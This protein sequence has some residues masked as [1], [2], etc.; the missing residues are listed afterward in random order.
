MPTSTLISY[1]LVLLLQ[2]F[3]PTGRRGRRPLRVRSAKGRRRRP[4]GRRRRH[5]GRTRRRR[6]FRCGDERVERER[7]HHS[8]AVFVCC[9]KAMQ[10]RPLLDRTPRSRLLCSKWLR[11]ESSTARNRGSRRIY[12]GAAQLGQQARR[13]SGECKEPSFASA[14]RLPKPGGRGLEPQII[15]AK[16][17]APTCC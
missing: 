9:S 2:V 11:T 12:A 8:L 16:P 5:R 4:L 1:E 3:Y 13:P 7:G 6:R 17:V 10:L 15:V 14:R